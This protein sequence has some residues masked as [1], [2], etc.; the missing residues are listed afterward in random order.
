MQLV[1]VD[2]R[3]RDR[4][5]LEQPGLDAPVPG[6]I[7]TA[8][9]PRLTPAAPPRSRRREPRP[10]RSPPATPEPVGQRPRRQAPRRGNTTPAG[11]P[12]GTSA[13]G[14]PARTST[15]P[16]PARSGEDQRPERPGIPARRPDVRVMALERV[17]DQ[18]GRRLEAAPRDD[19]RRPPEPQ[20]PRQDVNAHPRPEQVR[21]RQPAERAAAA[22]PPGEPDG[23]VKQPGLRIADERPAAEPRRVP[24][25]PPAVR[26]GSARRRRRTGAGRPRS[27]RCRA[28]GCAPGRRGRRSPARRRRSASRAMRAAGGSRAAETTGKIRTSATP[29][30][31]QR[32]GVGLRSAA[33]R[34]ADGLRVDPARPA[35]CAAC[36]RPADAGSAW[37]R[38]K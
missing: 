17:R 7:S 32:M 25:R 20:R 35:G 4:A 28:P 21:D 1:T 29:R 23:R 33:P 18:V 11:A 3:Q 12:S 15:R 38:S 9:R 5:R 27:G 16:P 6:Q 36:S 14:R 13:R 31:E 8:Q 34:S 30:G 2:L 26:A 37:I 22:R 24:G 10:R 19:R